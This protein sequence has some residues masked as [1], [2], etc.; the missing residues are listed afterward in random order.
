MK[1][2]TAIT[3]TEKQQRVNTRIGDE[4]AYIMETIQFPVKGVNEAD[5]AKNAWSLAWEVL[6]QDHKIVKINIAI[7]DPI[8]ATYRTKER[9]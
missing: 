1:E 5:A 6:G 4:L 9:V 7:A 8:K 3:I 2:Y